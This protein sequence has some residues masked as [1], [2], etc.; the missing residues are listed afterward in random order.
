MTF[1]L[2]AGTVIN[3]PKLLSSTFVKSI[4]RNLTDKTKHRI[5]WQP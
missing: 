2:L 5:S 3:A 1:L 4:A